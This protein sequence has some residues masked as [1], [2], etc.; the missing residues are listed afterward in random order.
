M[1]GS[2]VIVVDIEL[3]S[4][5]Q[6]VHTRSSIASHGCVLLTYMPRTI[7]VR[8]KNCDTV[9]LKPGAD[10]LQLG[11]MDMKGILGVQPIPRPW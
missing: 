7:Y 6:P 9:F 2:P 10:A 5:E 4:R 11:T 8:V 3:H 1:R